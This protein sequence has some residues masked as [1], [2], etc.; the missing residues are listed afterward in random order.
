MPIGT[1]LD[2]LQVSAWKPWWLLCLNVLF[3]A[4]GGDVHSNEF[5][6]VSLKIAHCYA[7]MGNM[8]SAI[9][10]YHYCIATQVATFSD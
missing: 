10:G 8:E 3:I 1:S 2:V 4:D 5:V 9:K 6:A 7:A